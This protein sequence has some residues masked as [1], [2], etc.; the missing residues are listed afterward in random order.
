MM[1]TV[2]IIIKAGLN[3]SIANWTSKMIIAKP[4]TNML[5]TIR[6][7][8]EKGHRYILYELLDS[9]LPAA[10]GAKAVLAQAHKLRNRSEYDGDPIDVTLGLVD[11]LV[12]AVANVREEVL[13]MFKSFKPTTGEPPARPN[14]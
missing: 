13:L 7:T 11:D 3:L 8:G 1:A 10:A 2:D 9:L 6:P 14:R 12:S 5:N 4:I